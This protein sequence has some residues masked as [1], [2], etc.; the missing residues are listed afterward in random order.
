MKTENKNIF[1]YKIS[2]FIFSCTSLFL[3]ACQKTPSKGDVKSTAS[4]SRPALKQMSFLIPGYGEFRMK[5]PRYWLQKTSKNAG[6]VKLKF[7]LYTNGPESLIFSINN[8]K[9]IIEVTKKVFSS[10]AIAKSKHFYKISIKG[11][12]GYYKIMN[13]KNG[14]ALQHKK[15]V[16][17]VGKFVVTV[18]LNHKKDH[19]FT[20]ILNVAGNMKQIR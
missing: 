7:S 17:L 3:S 14:S 18:Y 4:K 9:K 12:N 13:P 6:N 16:L 11:V 5:L 1:I 2:I 15:I 10:L 19:L 8:D 20:D